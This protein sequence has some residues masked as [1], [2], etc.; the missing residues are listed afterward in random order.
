[1]LLWWSHLAV[2]LLIC[3]F[4]WSAC[5][6]VFYFLS[7]ECQNS[8]SAH[9]SVLISWAI[10]CT[11]LFALD[12]CDVFVAGSVTLLL[13]AALCI[14]E[15]TCAGSC[16]SSSSRIVA[17]SLVQQEPITVLVCNKHIRPGISSE[18]Y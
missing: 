1:M 15:L 2:K 10:S 14:G 16:D 6:V 5:T 8:H 9:N 13:G 12:C 11:P 3:D 7:V 18:V 4:G 17:V